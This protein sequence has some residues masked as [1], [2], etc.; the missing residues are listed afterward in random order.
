[1]RIPLFWVKVFNYEYWPWWLFY[2]PMTPYW[3]LQAVRAKSLTFFTAVNPGIEAG[4]FYGE[5]K[6]EILKNI[7]P[8]Y[9]AKTIFIRF[10]IP[11]DEV[12]KLLIINNL[13]Y[14][15][16]AKP[17]VGERGNAVAKIHSEE[18][19]RQYHL[20]TKA[21][22]LIQEFVTYSIEFGVLFSRMP[23]EKLGKVSSIT[24]KEFLTV[25]GDGKSTIEELILQNTRARFQL[26][27]LKQKL[28]IGI[29]EILAVDENRLLEPIG[30]HCRGTKFVNANYLLNSELDAVFAKISES[31]DGFFYGRF[32]LKVS[33]IE[34]LYLGKNI[35]IMELNGVSSDPGHIYDPKYYLWNAYRDLMWHW[36][37]AANISIVNQKSGVNPLPIKDI[38]AIIKEHFA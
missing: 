22:Y 29:Q 15:I 31:F 36:K 4:G 9:L 27:S 8:D 19:L 37:R 18:E 11:F 1:M 17:N 12:C 30:N 32:D 21:D 26:E 20:L 35:K 24:R 25:T 7:S 14:P 23:N 5:H 33:S 34:D 6:T 38:F 28:G 2:L 13:T 3:L 10:D 16:I